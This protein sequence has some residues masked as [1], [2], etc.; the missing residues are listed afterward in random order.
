MG[1]NARAMTSSHVSAATDVS[2]DLPVLSS[3]D[4]LCDA[5]SPDVFVRFS[6]G[7][8]DDV[9]TGSTD[10]ESGLELPGLS[11]NPLQP[12]AW[13]ERP[14]QEWLAR[15]ICNYVHIQEES[16][17]DRRAWVLT[18][19]VVARGPDNEPLV[20]DYRPV[21]WLSDDLIRQAKALYR[22]AFDVA[23]DSTG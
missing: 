12:E 2:D 20:T 13:W 3:L 6:K 11:V 4:E 1:Q 7:P 5:V 17:D 23:K 8:E 21:A 14:L 19:R 10:Y 9:D 22:K 16:D 15:Q 18:G